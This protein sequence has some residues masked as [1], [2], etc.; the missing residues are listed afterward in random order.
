MV[1]SCSD[2]VFGKNENGWVLTRDWDISEAKVDE[3]EAKFKEL[4][5]TWGGSLSKHDQGTNR[6]PDCTYLPEVYAD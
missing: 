1:Y 3:Y 4:M 5:P 6:A 2:T